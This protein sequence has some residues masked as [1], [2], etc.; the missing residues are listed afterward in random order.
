VLDRFEGFA[1]GLNHPEGI[2]WNPF[3]GRLYAGGEGGECYAVS[4]DGAVTLVASTGGSMLGLAVDGAGRVYACDAGNGEVV[5]FHPAA[6]TFEVYARGVGGIDMDEPN[7]A[8]FAPDGSLFVT[9]S[10]E[11]R[12][13]IVRIA[14]SRG[15]TTWCDRVTR[16]PNGMVVT[17]DTTALLV[18]EAKAERIVRIPILA[19]GRAGDPETFAE[20]PD[21][22]ADGLALDAED[23]VWATLYRPDGLVRISPAGEE[24]LRIDD[25]LASTF[26]APT[27]LAFVGPDLD[28]VVVANVGGRHLLIADLGVRGRPLHYPE[29]P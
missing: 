14:P 20:L 1:D 16:Y 11:P 26:E 4:M 19:D 22:D 24:V 10:G 6:G 2:A 21:T 29:V 8:A 7:V 13:E 12:S 3:D 17:P 9:C 25:H 23:H 5:R 27:N 15:V 18:I 28:R